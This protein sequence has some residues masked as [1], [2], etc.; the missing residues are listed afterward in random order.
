VNILLYLAEAFL[1]A[2]VMK[3]TA[4]KLNLPT[5]SGYVVGGVILGGSL[6]FWLPGGQE[7]S[8]RWLL[9]GEILKQ[10][11]VITQ[12]ALGIISLS[13]GVELEW[14]RLKVLGKSIAAITVCEALGAFLLVGGAILLL[15]GDLP[16]ALILGAVSSA[17]APAATVAVI[18]QY[19]AKGPLTTTV[20]AVI[21]ID[22]A[23]SLIIFAFSLAIA[24]GNLRGE[25]ISIAASILKPLEDIS[26]AVVIGGLMGMLTARLLTN[27]TEH[28]SIVFYLGAA[29][30]LIAGIAEKMGLSPLLANMSYGAVLVNLNPI[31]KN[32]IRVGFESFMPIFYA[33][34]FL[35][36]GA[37][38]NITGFPVIWLMAIVYFFARTI[39]K[40][41]GAYGGAVVGKALPQ[42]RKYIGLSLLPQVG[43][44]I[45]IA[46]VIQNEF[47]S[48][49]YGERGISIA[50][51][52]MN[53]LLI[54]TLLTEFIGPY[55]TRLSLVKAGEVKE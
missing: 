7:F 28:D 51:N 40:A 11:D 25:E 34:F 20:L 47:G 5:V 12:I 52:T 37:Y 35:I 1:V 29:V 46:L 32:R 53:I 39:G 50:K 4:N 31:V 18:Q 42:V 55:L 48:G 6:F 13:I 44:A 17:T 22:D 38:L 19:R 2:L 14:S 24:R 8:S 30:F 10:F 45:A 16:F 36:G 15:T 54:T 3:T 26:L 41:I 23:A 27:I 43:V 33:L 9:G 21:G 49:S